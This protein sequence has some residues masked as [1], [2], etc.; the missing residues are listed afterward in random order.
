MSAFDQCHDQV[1]RA[2]EK[3]GWRLEKAPLRVQVESRVAYIDAEMSRGMNGKRESLLLLEV[4][5]FATKNATTTELYEAI[6]QYLVYRAMIVEREKPH[7]VYLAVP[8]HNFSDIFDSPVMR[9]LKESQIKV[10]VVNL[11]IEEVVKWIET[12]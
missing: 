10:I 11:E 5:C 7:A 6:G 12:L 3:A 8:E 2:L 9:V 1:V 4:K